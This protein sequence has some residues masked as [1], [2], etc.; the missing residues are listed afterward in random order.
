MKSSVK[1]RPMRVLVACVPLLSWG[2]GQGTDSTQL[3]REVRENVSERGRPAQPAPPGLASEASAPGDLPGGAGGGA[4]SLDDAAADAGRS[5]LA[6]D[7]A[8]D[9]MEDLPG[10]IPET[11]NDI[12]AFDVPCVY[13][14]R[15]SNLELSRPECATGLLS[16]ALEAREARWDGETLSWLGEAVALEDG[17]FQRMRSCARQRD[18]AAEGQDQWRFD[19]ELELASAL[20]RERCAAVLGARYFY[21]ECPFLYAGAGVCGGGQLTPED[22]YF[23]EG[24]PCT[25]RAVATFIPRAAAG[26]AG[27]AEPPS[28]PG[29]LP[30][31]T[32]EA[33]LRHPIAVGQPCY[34]TAHCEA[35][36]FCSFELPG[37]MCAP[38]L[39]TCQVAPRISDCPVEPE[40]ARTCF[41]GCQVT[42]PARGN[43]LANPCRVQAIMG[44]TTLP[45][46]CEEE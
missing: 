19:E 46:P 1:C 44:E 15:W 9:L 16:K 5:D 8:A 28:E 11:P 45:G 22:P 6:S 30:L 10:L 42:L 17:K 29:C 24:N 43:E 32:P 40:P 39:G 26:D 13:E 2:C 18:D 27:V 12:P 20:P 4:A 31:S 37:D 36:S 23:P 41:G 7:P 33:R 35:G 25:A 21:Q 34:S 14:V 3:T 38:R